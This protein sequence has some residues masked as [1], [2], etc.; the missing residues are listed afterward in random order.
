MKR[1]LKLNKGNKTAN[2]R[3]MAVFLLKS[4]CEQP[5]FRDQRPEIMCEWPEVRKERTE[6]NNKRTN[7]GKNTYM[8]NLQSPKNVIIL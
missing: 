5:D 2:F 8:C 3:G 1:L 4:N 7:L 6:I